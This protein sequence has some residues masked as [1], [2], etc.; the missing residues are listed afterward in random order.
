MNN[1]VK[2]AGSQPLWGDAIYVR[3]FMSVVDA[4]APATL[5]KIATIM[6]ANYRSY[7][8]AAFALEPKAK[9][10]WKCG[11]RGKLTSAVFEELLEHFRWTELE[12]LVELQ[13]DSIT[14]FALVWPN[15]PQKSPC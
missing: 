11:T 5:L 4:P 13:N 3:D 1:D 10:K 14:Q 12:E 7:D 15:A 2:S 6:H 9:R 8:F